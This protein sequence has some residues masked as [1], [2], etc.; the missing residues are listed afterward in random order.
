MAR[1]SEQ[2]RELT[3]ARLLE[4]AA[5]AF[6][7]DGLVGANINTISQEAGYAKGTIYNYFPS[8]EALFAAV[9]QEACDRAVTEAEDPGPGA[10]TRERLRALVSADVAWAAGNEAFARVFVHEV[11]SGDPNLFGRVVEAAA[12][13]T[14]R[15]VQVLREGADA[16]EVRTDR[17]VEELALLFSGMGLLALAQHW[18]SAGAWP[19]LE[20]IPDLVVDLFFNGARQPARTAAAGRDQ[21]P[22]KR[23]KG[24]MGERDGG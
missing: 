2:T 4:A 15:A 10:P 3:R 7:R 17:P 8:K 18:G 22:V 16:G 14:D 5:V 11:F 13:Y 9:V 20:E 12:P 1:V 23:R 19:A 24:G 21:A 6:A